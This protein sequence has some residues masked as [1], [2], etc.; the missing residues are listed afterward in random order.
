MHSD[1]KAGDLDVIEQILVRVFDVLVKR[2]AQFFENEALCDDDFVLP[3]G[4]TLSAQL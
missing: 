3:G 1:G 4:I 2:K